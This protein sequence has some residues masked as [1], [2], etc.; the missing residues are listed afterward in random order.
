MPS[1]GIIA[2]NT[3]RAIKAEDEEIDSFI[4]R[5]LNGENSKVLARMFAKRNQYFW[6]A[7]LGSNSKRS[8]RRIIYRILNK[9][10]FCLHSLQVSITIGEF[11]QLSC[12]HWKLVKE[13]LKGE[14]RCL[15]TS[16]ET[17]QVEQLIKWSPPTPCLDRGM[18]EIQRKALLTSCKDVNFI[19]ERCKFFMY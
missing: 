15:M 6:S 9:S 14:S 13:V 8:K 11:D 4:R 3:H 1:P 12:E 18:L 10:E 5:V 7:T 16:L 17:Q 2:R 19:T